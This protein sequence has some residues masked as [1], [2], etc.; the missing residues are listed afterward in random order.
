MRAFVPDYTLHTPANCAAALELLAR[1][2]GTWRPFAGGTD[3]MVL[4]EAGTLSHTHWIN[5][6]ALP[7]LHGITV[8]DDGIRLGACTTYTAVQRHEVLRREFPALVAAA[9]VT[10]AVA[11][12]N[13]GT[14]GGNIVNASPAADS[15]PALLAYDA[16]LEIISTRGMRSVP[17]ADFHTGYKTM[18]LRPDELVAAVHLP[19]VPHARKHYYRKVGTRKAQAITKVG[20]AGC[21]TFDG[22]RI[23]QARIAY[24]SVAPMPLRCTATEAVLEGRTLTQERI[25]CA[26]QQ[27]LQE[28]RP[29]DDLRASA[30][31]RRRVAANLLEEFLQTC[32]TGSTR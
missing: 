11:I 8:R 10:G 26:T 9:A 6:A 27:M 23:A 25:A 29:I 3:L 22:D 16:H 32:G 30:V 20:L 1:A 18:D 24:A 15:L 28:I 4:F 19:R 14:L 5:I 13:R 21:M 12:Q 31:F 7:E 2:P 17:Y